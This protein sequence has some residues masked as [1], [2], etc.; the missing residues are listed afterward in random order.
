MYLIQHVS[1]A[2]GA[3][4]PAVAGL[5]S[6][7]HLPGP[8]DSGLYQVLPQGILLTVNSTQEKLGREISWRNVIKRIPTSFVKIIEIINEDECRRPDNSP[9]SYDDAMKYVN[10]AF[11]N[12]ESEVS[13]PFKYSLSDLAANCSVSMPLPATPRHQWRERRPARPPSPPLVRGS[14]V[15]TT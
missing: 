11:E 13:L 5:L 2:G 3:G 7:H 1:C 15:I 4:C 8:P 10:D 6:A 12:S 14:A 9:P